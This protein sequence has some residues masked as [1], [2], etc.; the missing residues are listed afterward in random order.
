MIGQYCIISKNR[1]MMKKVYTSKNQKYKRNYLMLMD[2]NYEKNFA[3][4]KCFTRFV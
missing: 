3:N 4:T 1:F 2:I